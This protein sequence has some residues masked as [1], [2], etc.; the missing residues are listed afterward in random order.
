MKTASILIATL[1]LLA[2]TALATTYYVAKTGDNSNSGTSLAAPFLTIQKAATNMVAGDSCY[3][4]QGT[5]RETVTPANSGTSSARITFAPYA[6]EKVVVSGADV[7]NLSW[8]VHSGSIYKAT[9]ALS[10]RQLFV[11]GAMMNEAR[12][13]N[14]QTDNLLEAPRARVGSG[15]LTTLTDTDMPNVNLVGGTV[16]FFPGSTGG[17]WAANS[18]RITAQDTVLKKITWQTNASYNL[19]VN[20]PYYLYGKLELLDIATEWYLD[21]GASTLYL[22]TPNGASPASHTTEVKARASGFDLD[23]RAY[24]T[25]TGLYIFAA[26]ISMTST[27]NCV[28]DNCHLRY[29]RHDTTVDWGKDS[30]V[31]PTCNVT[32]SGSVWKNSSI[33]FSSQ[34]GLELGGVGA[35]VTNCVIRNVDYYPGRYFASVTTSSGSNHVIIRNTFS[36][37]GRL[38]VWPKTPSIEVAYNEMSWGNRLTMDGGAVYIYDFD[39]RGTKIHHNWAHHTEVGI[40]LDN[41]TTN[42][43]VYRNVCFDN[44]RAGIQLNA[45]GINHKIYNNTLVRNPTSIPVPFAGSGDPSQAGTQVINTLGDRAMS[46]LAD[47]TTNKN[48]WYPPVGADFVPQT[49]SGAINAGQIIPGYTDGYLGAGPDIGAYE[50]GAAYWTPGASFSIPGFPTPESTSAPAAPTGLTATSSFGGV[51]LALIPSPT[52]VSYYNVKRATTSGGPY[53]TVATVIAGTHYTDTNAISGTTYYYV[54][55]AVNSTGESPNSAQTSA[56]SKVPTPWTNYEI[57]VV[58]TAGGASYN[59]GIFTVAG[60]GADDGGTSDSFNYLSKSM[61]GD[62]TIIGRLVTEETIRTTDKVG[63]MMRADLTP[64]S[65]AVAVHLVSGSGSPPPAAV[66]MSRSASGGSSSTITGPGGLSLPQWFKLVRVGNAF[67]GYVS[68][69]GVAWTTVGSRTITMPSTIYVGMSVCSRN[70]MTLN[71]STF[72]NVTAPGWPPPPTGVAATA[73]SSSQINVSWTAS[74]GATSYKVKRATVSS[75]PYT[76]VASGVSGTTFSN[77]GLAAST[78]YYYVVSAM[79]GGAESANSIEAGAT[80]LLPTPAAPTGLT[81]ASASSSQINLSWTASSGATSYNVKRATVSGGPYT[82]VATGVT[83]TTFNNTGLAASTTYYYVVSAV[84]AGGESANSSQASATTRPAAPTGL[85]ASAGNGQVSLSWTASTGATSYNVKRATVSGGPYTTIATGVA[86]TSFLNTG[87]VNGTAYYFVVSAVNAGGESGNSAQASATPS[88]VLVNRATGGTALATSEKAPS[89]TAAMAFDG[90]T[91]TKWFNNNGGNTGWLRYHFATGIAWAVT[92]YDLSSANDFPG[93]DP[94]DWQFQG[95]H[96]G[97]SWTTVDTRAGQVFASRFQTI[98]YNFSNSTAYEYY[99]LNI[100]ANNGDA[101]GIQ[102]SELALMAD[103]LPSP[104]VTQD[105]GA[106]GVAGSASYSTNTFTLTGSGTDIW[107]ANDEFRYVYQP[108]SG[109]CTI[110]A[111]VATIES[112]DPW[113]KGGVMIRESLDANSA[114]ASVF[115]TPSNGVSFQRRTSTGAISVSTTTAGLTAPHW[116]KVLR[117][118]STFSGSRSVDGVTWTTIGSTT[119]T[120]GTSVHLGLAITSHDNT[121]LCT[122]TMDNVAAFDSALKVWLKFDEL[123]GALATDSSRNANDATL[124]NGPLWTPGG[125]DGAVDLDGVDDHLALPAGQANYT[126]GMTF[127]VWA[128]PVTAGNFAR[129]FDFGNGAGIDN[130]Y[131]SRDSTNSGLRFKV[132]NGTNGGNALVVTNVIALNQWQQFAVTVDNAGNAKLYKNGLQIGSGTTLAPLNVIRTNNFIGR[133]NWPNNDNFDGALDDLRVYNRVLSPAEIL[134]LP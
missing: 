69:D 48:G 20:N 52:T 54:V 16:H 50:T 133:S 22:W 56:V 106:V 37:S 30:S 19:S 32:G 42:F 80:T 53:T 8:S 125:L 90:L 115:V 99:R 85:I 95:S 51:D 1:G 74:A 92:R 47:A 87:L 38:H 31:P 61:T 112:V 108:V 97:V 17:E 14:A 10:F 105:I 9:T 46:F 41:Y 129:F 59:N 110:V 102:L 132:F 72:D 63:L 117:I 104:W 15:T 134:G 33:M 49:G 119:I 36:G 79:A 86:G 131:L 24:I 66:L 55:S 68:P 67:T 40:Y 114:Y 76:T 88:G 27:T 91:S 73:V 13:P 75:G 5:Y 77:T 43:A 130:I 120:M 96:D 122:A 29:V 83:G 12:W 78:T 28:V 34:N 65:M 18:R 45:P 113:S 93:R 100:T 98:Q 89:E 101:L 4:R 7:L 111:R 3:I 128:Y 35:L 94:K 84:N 124:V 11:D 57:G 71:T 58:G 82:T 116:V 44:S 121:N 103:Q 118:G 81:A 23:N 39:G 62:G 107:L 60:A 25:V 127:S 70:T 26:D 64:G 109:D 126:N 6:G 123:S 21:N 2:Q